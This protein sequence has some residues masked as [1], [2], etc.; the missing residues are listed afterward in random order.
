MWH[1]I[2]T[3]GPN[4]GAISHHTSVV[5]NERMYLFGGSKANGDENTKFFSLDIKSFRW[6]IIQ[7]VSYYNVV[8]NLQRG[9]VPETRDEHTAIIY[10]GS[11]IIFGGFVNGVR[12]NDIY[13]YYFND[14]RW[15]LIK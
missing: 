1:H 6:E 2:D 9:Q 11:M 10:E 12:S 15:E 8:T 4:P 3:S 14:N 13:R 5:F 7:S